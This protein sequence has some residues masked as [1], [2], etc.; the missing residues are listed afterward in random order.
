M[1]KLLRRVVA[2]GS[3][4]QRYPSSLNKCMLKHRSERGSGLKEPITYIWHEFEH[5]CL[6]WSMKAEDRCLEK[7]IGASKMGFEPHRW[8]LNIKAWIGATRLGFE[9]WGWDVS[10]EAG[11]W[12]W[13][14]NL[15][16]Q[17]GFDPQRGWID[18]ERVGWEEEGEIFLKCE[19]ISHQPL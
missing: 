12:A 9:P 10:L 19:S 18:G 4:G 2:K 17:A 14:L 6:D 16:L 11:I 1:S 8:D 7:R 5:R 15:S 3:N 13:M